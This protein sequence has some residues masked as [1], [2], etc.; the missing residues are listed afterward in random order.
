V[1]EQLERESL[2]EYGVSFVR[3]EGQTPIAPGPC[4]A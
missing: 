2:G 4:P 1:L 3:F